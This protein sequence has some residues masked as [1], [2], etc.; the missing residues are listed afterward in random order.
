MRLHR[1][2]RQHHTQQH[3]QIHQFTLVSKFGSLSIRRESQ[4]LLCGMV[5]A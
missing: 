3:L 5:L 2:P 4:T 1:T